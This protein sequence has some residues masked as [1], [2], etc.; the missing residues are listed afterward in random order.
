MSSQCLCG[1][2]VQLA[3]L[4]V[5]TMRLGTGVQDQTNFR[6]AMFSKTVLP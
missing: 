4:S 5:L 1:V 6:A 3:F 2:M